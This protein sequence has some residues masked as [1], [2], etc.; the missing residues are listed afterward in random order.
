M[1]DNHKIREPARYSINQFLVLGSRI[2]F[3]LR[4]K[5]IQ[6]CSLLDGESEAEGFLSCDA[7]EEG[8]GWTWLDGGVGIVELDCVFEEWGVEDGGV[9]GFVYEE[10]GEDGGGRA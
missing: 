10:E 8:G 9:E 4:E 3:T 2:I 7:G 1:T 5:G 6:F